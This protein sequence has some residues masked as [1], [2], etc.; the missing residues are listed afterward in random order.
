MNIKKIKILSIISLSFCFFSLAGCKTSDNTTKEITLSTDVL[1]DLSNEKCDIMDLL[2]RGNDSLNIKEFVEAKSFFEKALLKNKLDSK[3][4]TSIISS[5]TNI[6]RFDDAYYFVNL[7]IDNGVTSDDIQNIKN[8]ILS[9]FEPIALSSTIVKTSSFSL[10]NEISILVNNSDTV[11]SEVTW[12]SNKNIDTKNTGTF[13]FNGYSNKYNRKVSYTLI[14]REPIKKHIIGFATDIYE[15]NNSMYLDFDE[16]Q[17]YTFEEAKR[18]YLEDH[19][20]DP[21]LSKF[22]NN[23]QIRNPEIQSIVYKIS[24]NCSF[25]LCEFI[26]EEYDKNK[27]SNKIDLINT[28]Y[29]TFYD[30]TKKTIESGNSLLKNTPTNSNT[31]YYGNNGV[32]YWIDTE[33]GVIVNISMQFTP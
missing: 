16:A 12:E 3:T 33:D 15:K 29:K 25:N 20:E 10:P 11:Q 24:P 1:Q 19:P 23:Y 17:F 22:Y 28:N 2:Q 7:A 9:K 8:N 14:I 18:V 21:N 13:T 4:Y 26:L 5:Y 31:I 30:Y 6:N 27:Y 32:L